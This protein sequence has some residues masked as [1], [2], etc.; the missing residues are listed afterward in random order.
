[1]SSTLH[2]HL[3]RSRMDPR[4]EERALQELAL[5]SGPRKPEESELSPEGGAGGHER[6][7]GERVGLSAT[8]PLRLI[9]LR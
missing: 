9:P 7:E 3:V 2:S 6:V 4:G 1:M 5:C 8:N